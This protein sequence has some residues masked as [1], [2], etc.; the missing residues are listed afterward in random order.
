MHNKTTPQD[1]GW[2]GGDSIVGYW[3]HHGLL[4][5]SPF[6][7]FLRFEYEDEEEPLFLAHETDCLRIL[8]RFAHEILRCVHLSS[9]FH[10]RFLPRF[11]TY[12]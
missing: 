10:S 7:D 5:L 3:R 4:M 2:C 9:A 8:S 6:C 1:F 11:S 12:T